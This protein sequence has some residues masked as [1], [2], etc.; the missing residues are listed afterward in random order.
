[1]PPKKDFTAAIEE[2]N[3]WSGK[4]FD[5]P[6]EAPSIQ[7]GARY[8]IS[9]D[10]ADAM[11]EM[12]LDACTRLVAFGVRPVHL[13]GWIRKIVISVRGGS[14]ELLSV[15]IQHYKST[16][17]LVAVA[18]VLKRWPTITVCIMQYSLPKAQSS[19]RLL[20]EYAAAMGIKFKD[21][22]STITEWR[23]VE[24][25]GCIVMS[26]DQSRAGFAHD[27]LIPDDPVD[28]HSSASQ[29]Q[30]DAADH[31]IMLYTMRGASH[32]DSVLMVASPWT[33]DDPIIRCS[34]RGWNYEVFSQII[35][36]GLPTE[37]SY[38]P[39]I[40]SLDKAKMVRAEQL[41]VDPTGRQWMAQRMC[42]PLPPALGFFPGETELQ[43]MIPLDAPYAFGLDCAFTS[44]PK[45][46]WTAIVGGAPVQAGFAIDFGFRG[47]IGLMNSIDAVLRIAATRPDA[48][49]YTY[50]SGPE[51]GIYDALA[52]QTN[53]NLQVMPAK[54]NKATRAQR[55]A[56]AWQSKRVFVK[57]R[58]PWTA[59][60][61]A[62]HHGFDGSEV[63]VDDQVD[64]ATALYDGA[65]AGVSMLG[66]G[67]NFT[68]GGSRPGY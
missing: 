25:G 34:N 21:G 39:D 31:Q 65:M 29:P 36:E 53:L 23:T 8:Q 22:H 10:D 45:S 64:A 1:M 68:F 48:P 43:G 63:G 46:D 42:R 24:G 60:F 35:D 40:L 55:Y 26:V 16:T 32:I 38:C 33:T 2:S 28:E 5:A 66:F 19:G 14:R 50:S 30:R 58:D 27:I 11:V 20:R 49:W 67:Q 47:K 59:Q 9:D 4:L 12:I 6:V 51:R 61:L 41:L 44:S 37:R 54:F 62:E 52:S 18:A 57:L 15:P 56:R 13:R 7:I 3:E 17:T